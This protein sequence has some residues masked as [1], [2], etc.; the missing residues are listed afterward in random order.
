MVA[1][2][3]AVIA[4]VVFPGGAAKTAAARSA[5][6]RGSPS[7]D[8]RQVATAFLR[9]WQRGDLAQAAGYTS[10][11]DA[12]RATLVAFRDD[13]H[14]RKLT[15]RVQAVTEQRAAAAVGGAQERV[16]YVVSATVALSDDPRALSGN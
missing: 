2:A 3:A 15:T 6:S 8:G 7:R 1:S 12:A 11:P 4:L 14:L 9:A 16:R 5:V 13:L 10:S